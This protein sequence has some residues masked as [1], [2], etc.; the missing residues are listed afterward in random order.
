MEKKTIADNHDIKNAL[1]TIKE[2]CKKNNE[3]LSVAE[4]V[5]SGAL[6]LLFSSEEEAGLFYEGGMTVYSLDQ[7]ES[8]L[9][10]S[11]EITQP[12]QGVSSEIAE[13]LA[14]NIC[15]LYKTNIGMGLTGFASPFPEK[16]IYE[17]FA[18]GA[19]YRNGKLIFCEKIE[20]K[21]ETPEEKREDYA[22]IVIKKFAAFLKE[23]G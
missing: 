1:D 17:L 15:K 16:N 8:L 10:I 2:Y 9:G 11:K 7:K 13:N 23:K 4:S 20:S 19:A 3:T 14:K 5:S 18:Y 6:Q 21:K 12:C 22:K